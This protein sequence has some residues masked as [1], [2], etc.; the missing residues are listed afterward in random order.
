VTDRLFHRALNDSW[1]RISH[2]EGVYLYDEEGQ[3]WL[4]ACAGV[5]VVSIGHGVPE[6]AAAMEAQA[7]KVCFTY[8]R[9]LTQPQIDLA[10]RTAAMTPGDLNRVFF[11]S[12]GS[13]ATE[14]AMK[15]ADHPVVLMDGFGHRRAFLNRDVLRMTQLF[16]GDATDGRGHGRRKE[17]RL[18]F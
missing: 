2:G 17:R 9:F 4:D 12:G 10:E 14:S 7:R 3:Q 8:A 6:I 16:L 15:I 5:H 13:E 1:L 11:V 18:T